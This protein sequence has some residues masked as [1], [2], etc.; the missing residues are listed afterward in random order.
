MKPIAQL[1]LPEILDIV[2]RG[3]PAEI[4]EVLEQLHPADVSVVIG[5]LSD[6]SAMALFLAAPREQRVAVFEHLEEDQQ[7]RV[8]KL[9]GA[10]AMVPIV[11]EMAS[12]DRADLLQSLPK[13]LADA[14][15]EELSRPE[16]QDVA[17][18]I[19]YPEKTAGAIMTT[20]F[21]VVP[22][23]ATVSAAMDHLRKVAPHRET[24]YYVYVTD[25]E[26]HLTGVLSLRDLVLADPSA[27]VRSIMRENPIALPVD[28]DQEEVAN[29][30][31]KYDFLAVPIVD[32]KLRLVGIVTHDD[33]IDVI[34]EESTE[35][36]Q[37][38]G[39]ITP[40][41]ETYLQTGFWD[42]LRKRG[43]WLAILFFAV[44][45]TG[46]ALRLFEDTIKSMSILVVFVPLIV[47][48][49]GNVGSQSAT[50]IIRALAVGDIRLKDWGRVTWREVRTGAALGLFLGLMGVVRALL[51]NTG[52]GVA[53]VVGLTVLGIVIWAALVGSLL[54]IALRRMGMDPAVASAAFIA[55]IVD[56][57][58]IVMYFSIAKLLLF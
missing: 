48:T 21:A 29:Q 25:E 42:I 49:G 3:E 41:Q 44:M 56:V 11:E 43:I 6:D 45:Y 20:E 5:E 2:S 14:L 50:L 13:R 15:I 55:S 12:D 52:P 24:I 47:S 10:R 23:Y 37:R 22:A 38:M 27:V 46:T 18:L 33:A 36:A 34:H 19:Q 9:V 26:E 17:A 4:K 53:L 54:P 39:A 40:L 31:A 1:I 58:G 57:V 35:D 28:C 32:S 16:Q 7:E 51:W 30:L 8:L